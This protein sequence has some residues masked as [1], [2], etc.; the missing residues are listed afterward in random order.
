MALGAEDHVRIARPDRGKEL[1]Q[2]PSRDVAVAVDEPEVAASPL[3][4]ADVQR[5]SL[6]PVLG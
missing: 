4:Q 6:A 5:G 1:A 3:S 2:L